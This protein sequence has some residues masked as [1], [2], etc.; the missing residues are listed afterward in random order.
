[1]SLFQ[2]FRLAC[3]AGLLFQ[4]GKSRQKRAGETPDPRFFSQSDTIRGRCLV[5][6][7]I[8]LCRW[9]PRNRCGGCL[10]SAVAPRADRRFLL[11]KTSDESIP[12]KGRQAKS[13][14]QPTTGQMPGGFSDSV[15]AQ[16]QVR[17]RPI[18]QRIPKP[19][20]WRAFGYFSRVGKV[21]RRRQDTP[22][23]L[24]QTFMR[25]KPPSRILNCS[26]LC[27]QHKKPPCRRYEV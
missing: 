18:G 25:K 1:M 8:P 2:P 20:F 24:T 26:S 22:A 27:G 4:R 14:A 21:P 10:T 17:Y 7:E 15:A 19:W 16:N 11:C 23:I 5:A 9:P 12:S 13:D 3:S 6:T